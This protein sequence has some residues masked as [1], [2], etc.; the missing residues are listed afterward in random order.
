ML[1]L[2][3]WLEREVVVM[4]NCG[5]SQEHWADKFSDISRSRAGPGS[6]QSGEGEEELK[7]DSN[8]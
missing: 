7:A 6:T 1:K 3:S 8:N 4:E 5:L 2:M